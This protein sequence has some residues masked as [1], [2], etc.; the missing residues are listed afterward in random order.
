MTDSI[1]TTDALLEFVN[2]GLLPNTRAGPPLLCELDREAGRLRTALHELFDAIRLGRTPPTAVIYQVNRV[3]EAG[4]VRASLVLRDGRPVVETTPVGSGALGRLAPFALAAADLA[5]RVDGK[6]LRRC[7][8]EDC[9][10]WF[11]DTSKGGRRRWCSMARCGN[12]AKAARY[13]ERHASA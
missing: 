4:R 6:R 12:R 8:A 9:R 11:V 10:S 5:E 2:G 13:R 7:A 3:I 1:P